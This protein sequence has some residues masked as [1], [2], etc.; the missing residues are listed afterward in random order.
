MINLA[1]SG[2]NDFRVFGIGG[3]ACLGPSE[4]W[5]QPSWSSPQ[6]G[7][8][9]RAPIIRS[10]TPMFVMHMG[11]TAMLGMPA[12]PASPSPGLKVALSSRVTRLAGGTRPKVVTRGAM[13]P[14]LA[15]FSIF[16][17]TVPCI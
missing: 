9:R 10:A 2:R 6:H 7:H 5:P 13:L 17:P 8:R 14:N 1:V 15:A 4:H 16:V 12:F 11:V 3:S